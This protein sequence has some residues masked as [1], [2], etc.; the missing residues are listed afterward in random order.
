MNKKMNVGK[1]AL[2]LSL[3]VMISLSI[4]GCGKSEGSEGNEGT[5]LVVGDISDDQ[6]A[7]EVVIKAYN[8]GFTPSEI[9]VKKGETVTLRLVSESGFH[10]ISIPELGVSTTTVSAGE[11]TSVTFTA[12]KVGI[13]N[14]RCNIYCGD[15]HREMTGRV[16]VG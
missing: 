11:E 1:I 14:F 8:F 5:G 6:K 10:G 15:G 13:F 12:D 9:I 7:R 16:V 2:L 3:V 4:L